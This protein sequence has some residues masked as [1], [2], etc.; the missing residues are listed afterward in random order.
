MTLTINKSHPLAILV[1]AGSGL[2]LALAKRFA[3][4]NFAVALISRN[5]TSLLSET[6]RIVVV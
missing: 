1:G 5:K 3:R 6:F 2:G 4:E